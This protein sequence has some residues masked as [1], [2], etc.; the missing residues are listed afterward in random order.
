MSRLLKL[1]I[2]VA[3]MMT[4]DTQTN[5]FISCACTWGKKGVAHH[6]FSLTWL[7]DMFSTV[8]E[9]LVSHTRTTKFWIY[10][11]YNAVLET[12]QVAHM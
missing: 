3:T 1:A 7:K 2:F 12:S 6:Y 10:A 4:I 11:K 5:Y 9:P 8:H